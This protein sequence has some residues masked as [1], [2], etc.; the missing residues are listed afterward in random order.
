[1]FVIGSGKLPFTIPTESAAKS[2][3]IIRGVAEMLGQALENTPSGQPRATGR[4]A[5]QLRR[6]C[7]TREQRTSSQS[8]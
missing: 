1:M 3:K 6:A 7:A 2:E 8:T 4:W 5:S